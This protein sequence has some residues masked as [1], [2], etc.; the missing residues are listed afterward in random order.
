MRTSHHKNTLLCGSWQLWKHERRRRAA[1]SRDVQVP[2]RERRSDKVHQGGHGG[3]RGAAAGDRSGE[4][5]ER[6]GGGVQ[7]GDSPSVEGMGI[8]PGNKPWDFQGDSG[9][10]DARTG[11]GV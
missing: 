6:R 7:G 10:D 11:E 4:A 8:F 9:E 1:I 2:V 5:V 3:G